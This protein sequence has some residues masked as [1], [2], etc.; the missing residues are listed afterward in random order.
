MVLFVVFAIDIIFFK[1][2]ITQISALLLFIMTS[3][4]PFDWVAKAADNNGLARMAAWANDGVNDICPAGCLI[5]TRANGQMTT[6]RR[7]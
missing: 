2:A 1:T 4:L 6:L 5:T 3:A 7:I